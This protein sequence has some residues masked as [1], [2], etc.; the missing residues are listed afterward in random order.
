MADYNIDPDAKEI[1]DKE[2]EFVND[3]SEI[4]QN[5]ITYLK[6]YLVKP[7]GKRRNS[8]SN[9]ASPELHSEVEAVMTA[10]MEMAF[11]DNN[12]SGF[13]SALPAAADQAE[14]ARRSESV[15]TRQ[16]EL[17]KFKKKCMSFTRMLVLYGTQVGKIVWNKKTRE[18][19][20]PGYRS[21]KTIADWPDFRYQSM[22]GFRYDGGAR[23]IE[24]A[25]W[26]SCVIPVS[27]HEAR[28]MERLG[29]WQNVGEALSRKESR[30]QYR[31]ERLQLA[32]DLL[33][34][35]DRKELEVI[36]YYGTLASKN[37]DQIYKTTCSKSGIILASPELNPYPH[38]RRPALKATWI[39]IGDHFRG[40]GL[41]DINSTPLQ[42][43]TERKNLLLDGLKRSAYHM[44]I[45][46][47]GSGIDAEQLIYAPDGIIESQMADGLLPQRPDI[48]FIP[49]GL[50]MDSMSDEEM[51]RASAAM[52]TLQGVSL[53]ITA[54]ETRA[55]HQE[56][57]RRIKMYVI[58]NFSSFLEEVLMMYHE[59]NIH[60]LDDEILTEM[61]GPDGKTLFQSFNRH[62]LPV[63]LRI[64]LK[65]SADTGSRAMMQKNFNE[66]LVSLG[67]ILK[68]NPRY[69][70]N[71]MGAIQYAAKY[72]GF[73]PKEF[74]EE[75][76]MPLAMAN[77]LAMRAAANGM[78]SQGRDIMSERAAM[79][80]A[81]GGAGGY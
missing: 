79:L 37:D 42:E 73:D 81:N 41:G 46:R 14:L 11:S 22:L 39:D 47:E 26:Y 38:G 19:G 1:V 30:D 58:A 66:F 35:Q 68:D 2:R 6:Q 51:R 7:L 63:D 76:Q 77:P 32:G 29:K 80:A 67:V 53:D 57:V 18:V 21:T 4:L 72:H 74:I 15:I 16:L 8:Y 31:E 71:P 45:K 34:T 13:F 27:A 9:T 59:L 20:L 40:V 61:A 25:G 33:G 70:L 78:A 50:K 36:E 56:A 12:E 69:R 60:L 5:Y 62:H 3:N 10:I 48:S 23:D 75:M 65:P 52:S 43:K 49:L 24:D 44:W 55:V 17:S 54:T 28:V 64:K